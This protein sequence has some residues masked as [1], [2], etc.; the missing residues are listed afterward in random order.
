MKRDDKGHCEYCEPGFYQSVDFAHG[1]W[2]DGAVE[3]QAC[4]AGTYAKTVHDIAEFEMMPNFLNL[5]KCTAVT[6][7]SSARNCKLH[8][9]QWRTHLESLRPN[10]GIPPGLRIS[11]G[12]VVNVTNTMGGKMTIEFE[13]N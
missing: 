2:T 8:Q 11:I 6:Q 9:R 10:T 1:D 5:R 12:G 3:C 4:Q 7:G 13:T